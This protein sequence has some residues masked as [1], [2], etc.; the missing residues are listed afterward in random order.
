MKAQNGQ[1][2]YYTQKYIPITLGEAI[3]SSWNGNGSGNLIPSE[4]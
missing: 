2:K 1:Y 4:L 3:F